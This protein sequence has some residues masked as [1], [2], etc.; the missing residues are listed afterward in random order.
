MRVDTLRRVDRYV[1]IPLCWMLSLMRRIHSLI[2]AT[3]ELPEPRK[4]LIIKLS[5]MGST[6]LAYPALA[7]LKSRCPDA[8]L[9]FLVFAQNAAIIEVLKFAPPENIIK[10]DYRTPWQL[11]LSGLGAM[12][13]L[14]RERFDTAIDMDLFSRLTTL[15]SFVAC[16]GNRVGFHRYNDEGLYRGD[17]LTHRVLYSP[18]VHTSVAFASLIRSLVEKSKD[19]FYYRGHISQK[20]LTVPSHQPEA[21][22]LDSVHR[23]LRSAGVEVDGS[24]IV[25]INPNSSEIFPLR[26]WPLNYYAQLCRLLLEHVP[27][28]ALVI[29]GVASEKEDATYIREQVQNSRCIDF[30]GVT[31]FR[32][33]LALYSIAGGMV[34][35]DSGPA[36]FASLLQLPTVILF[37]PETPRLYSPIGDKHKDIYSNF[38]CSP[39][40]SVYNGK[41]SPC[42]ENRCLTV[43][44]PEQ[45]FKEVLSSLDDAAAMNGRLT[46]ASD[47]CI[48]EIQTDQESE[49]PL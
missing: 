6:V 35:N 15:I 39:C 24:I 19:N 30:T 49:R 46:T 17:L 47:L 3:P 11:L 36:H 34:T 45:V 48:D 7:E 4:V 38:A 31:N 32:E 5:E 22:D 40:V 18:H 2:W 43:I 44:T 27:R 12:L 9:Y 23:K 13:R 10:V 21:A 25:L 33:L 8:K 42:L 37:G 14:F 28:C 41:K 16:R 26:K 29:T 1:G 20:E